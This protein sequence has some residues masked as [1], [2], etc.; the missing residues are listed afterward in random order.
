MNPGGAS[1]PDAAASSL[2]LPQLPKLWIGYL[3]GV[4]TVVAEH[5]ALALHPELAQGTMGPPL[6][7]FLVNFVGSVYWLAC[8][9]RYHAALARV[10]GWQHPISPAKAV[11]YHFI[12]VYSLYWIF[13]WPIEVAKFVNA[14]FAKRVMKSTPVGVAF[15]MA[16]VLCFFDPGMGLFFLFLPLSYVSECL[17]RAFALR[18]QRLGDV[19]PDDESS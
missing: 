12:P 1:G 8:I 16:L 15:F 14:T 3:L 18:Q 11:G 17:R 4:A 19:P 7:L 10:P 6:Y 2:E 5:V 13:K 9:H